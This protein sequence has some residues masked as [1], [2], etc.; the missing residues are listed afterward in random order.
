MITQLDYLTSVFR[1]VV[2][3]TEDNTVR[4]GGGRGEQG[5]LFSFKGSAIFRDAK[6]QGLE[7]LTKYL[8]PFHF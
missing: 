6:W 7:G 2:L 1:A 3:I 5:E 8:L 4:V